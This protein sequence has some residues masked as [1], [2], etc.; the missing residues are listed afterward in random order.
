MDVDGQRYIAWE[1]ALE[2]E[3]TAPALAVGEL[4]RE[5]RCVAFSFPAERAREDIRTTA[6]E[7][8][9]ELVRTTEGLGGTMGI[10]AHKVSGETYR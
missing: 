1:E 6:G 4:L 5:A 8:A 3:I 2:R 7:V 10:A 9:G